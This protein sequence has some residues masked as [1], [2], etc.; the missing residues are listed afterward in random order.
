VKLGKK[1]MCQSINAAGYL[2]MKKLAL[3]LKKEAS[4]TYPIIP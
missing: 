4:E 2:L 1:G 3:A